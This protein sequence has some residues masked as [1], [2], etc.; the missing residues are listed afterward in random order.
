MGCQLKAGRYIQ[1][2][3]LRGAVAEAVFLKFLRRERG[4][5]AEWLTPPP[6]ETARVISRTPALTAPLNSHKV[7]IV[8]FYLHDFGRL[9]KV[10]TAFFYLYDF[11]RL[12]IRK[13]ERQ[14]V[15]TLHLHSRADVQSCVANIM[16]VL[17]LY[18]T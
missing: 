9:H 8:F 5:Y 4:L 7:H 6:R 15:E 14:K 10:H 12:H 16:R 18:I 13:K 3:M 1:A 17:H 11:G 2:R